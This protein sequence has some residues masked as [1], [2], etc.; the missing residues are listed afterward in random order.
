[1]SLARKF[2]EKQQRIILEGSLDYERLILTPVNEFVDR[3]V[4]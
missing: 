4:I 1:M 2:P 3:M